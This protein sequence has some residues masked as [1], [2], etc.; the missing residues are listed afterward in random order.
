MGNKVV[1]SIFFPIMCLQF[2]IAEMK[3]IQFTDGVI[4]LIFFE[5]KNFYLPNQNLHLIPNVIC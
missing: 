1:N 3:N 4:I 2:G 5:V